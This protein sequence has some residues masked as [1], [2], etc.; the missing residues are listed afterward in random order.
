MLLSKHG[1]VVFLVHNGVD[2]LH[3]HTHTHTHTL[4]HTHTQRE[5]KPTRN[6]VAQIM[7]CPVK[8]T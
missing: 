6:T 3:T 8:D 4:T 7:L 1:I 5:T 2:C